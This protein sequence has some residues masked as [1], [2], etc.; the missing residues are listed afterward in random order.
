MLR[1]EV[2]VLEILVESGRLPNIPTAP[3]Q[4]PYLYDAETGRVSCI[5][6]FALKRGV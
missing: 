1:V 3:Q 4:L 5:T 6:P 2:A